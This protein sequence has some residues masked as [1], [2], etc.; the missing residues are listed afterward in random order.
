M[1][2]EA[3]VDDFIAQRKLALVGMSSQKKKFG[4]AVY[5]ELISNGYEVF[6]VH[7]TAE[8][9]DGQTC[10]PS[11]SRLP[12]PVDGVVVVVPPKAA[13]QVVQ[14]S[15]EAGIRRVWLQQGAESPEVIRYGAKKNISIIHG[16]CILM[17][18]DSPAFIHRFHRWLWG[19]FGKLPK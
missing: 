8:S 17:F 9:I 18:L 10:W 1:T 2:T 4:N 11:L 6:P 12:E 15:G 5:R 14:E 19:V 3:D 13:K 7:P 16:E